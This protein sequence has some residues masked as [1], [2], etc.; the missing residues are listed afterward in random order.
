MGVD[1]DLWK[2]KLFL[3][4][5]TVTKCYICEWIFRSY[6]IKIHKVTSLE[7]EPDRSSWILDA[8]YCFSSKSHQNIIFWNFKSFVLSSSSNNQLRIIHEYNNLPLLFLEKLGLDVGHCG[9]G[10]FWGGRFYCWTFL[11]WEIVVL[12]YFAVG[13][14]TAGLFCCGRFWCWTF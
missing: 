12:G 13:D 1:K 7:Y 14:S 6:L 8:D 5:T 3:Q 4:N 2:L 10:L 11:L 9:T